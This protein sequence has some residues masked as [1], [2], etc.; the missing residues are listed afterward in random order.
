MSCTLKYKCIYAKLDMES[1]Y[2]FLCVYCYLNLTLILYML[3]W[4]VLVL[5]D[6]LR[7]ISSQCGVEVWSYGGVFGCGLCH[8]DVFTRKAFK[9]S[10]V[11]VTQGFSWWLTF[12]KNWNFVVDFIPFSIAATSVIG[13]L[14]LFH[15]Q[16]IFRVDIFHQLITWDWVV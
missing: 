5:Y 4:N 12:S 7:I 11:H 14:T 15:K 9:M 10:S 8:D 13:W 16:W 3:R 1:V 6:D 2:V